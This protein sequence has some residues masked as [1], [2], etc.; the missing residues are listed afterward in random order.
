MEKKDIK[1]Q[2]KESV[3]LAENLFNYK[4]WF[5]GLK[6][7]GAVKLIPPYNKTPNK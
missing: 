7:F 3:S 2:T 5:N 1:V 6:K 4:R